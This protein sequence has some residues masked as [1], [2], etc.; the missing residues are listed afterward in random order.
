MKYKIFMAFLLVL[1]I[2][3]QDKK[4]LKEVSKKDSKQVSKKIKEFEDYNYYGFPKLFS[5]TLAIYGSHTTFLDYK[6]CDS[7]VLKIDYKQK[8]DSLYKVIDDELDWC[9][10]DTM[11]VNPARRFLVRQKEIYNDEIKLIKDSYYHLG[12]RDFALSVEKLDPNYEERMRQT[13]LRRQYEQIL[14]FNFTIRTNITRSLEDGVNYSKNI[15]KGVGPY[16][17]INLKKYAN[18]KK[19]SSNR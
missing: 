14:L 17:G 6:K 7:L 19:I 11:W 9:E 4:D 2:G 16:Q 15:P 3:C 10:T 5:D 8:Q 18:L 1:V 13:I 12:G